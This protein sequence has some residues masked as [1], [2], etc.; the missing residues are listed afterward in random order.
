[1]RFKNTRFGESYDR[2]GKPQALKTI[3]APTPEETRAKGVLPELTPLYR[4]EISQPGNV[5]R[6]FER[7]GE[8]KTEIGNPSGEE[9]PGEPDD[10]VSDR[11]FWKELR[12]DPVFLGLQ[13]KG[14]LAPVLSLPCTNHYAG[15]YR[16]SGRSARH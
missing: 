12:T 3:P 8:K 15:D 7:G 9:R 10:K 14:T 13:K 5:L 6:V 1:M 4:W 16:S 11:G 2:N